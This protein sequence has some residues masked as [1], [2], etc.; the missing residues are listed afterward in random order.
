[1]VPDIELTDYPHICGSMVAVARD[2]VNPE[3]SDGQGQVSLSIGC[4]SR[5]AGQQVI[6]DTLAAISKVPETKAVRELARYAR[7]FPGI[8]LSLPEFH[9]LMTW[10]V[11]KRSDGI[12]RRILGEARRGRKLENHAYLVGLIERVRKVHEWSLERTL[13]WVADKHSRTFQMARS[14]IR[15]AYYE[16]RR[17]YHLYA[18][19]RFVPPGR[20]ATT[21]WRRPAT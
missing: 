21:R 8:V 10:L 1:M 3:P 20:L 11:A 18:G 17:R 4:E 2:P 14:S 6:D 9:E 16:N 7:D 19:S 13:D 5:E 12:I 15:N